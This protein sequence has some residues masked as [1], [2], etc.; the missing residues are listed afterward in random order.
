MASSGTQEEPLQFQ[1]AGLMEGDTPMVRSQT[2]SSAMLQARPREAF[3]YVSFENWHVSTLVAPLPWINS[4]S[5]G[6]SVLLGPGKNED[7]ERP[8]LP[9]RARLAGTCVQW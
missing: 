2:G 1:G 5:C 6:A 7:A 9:L 3:W 8:Q 4:H